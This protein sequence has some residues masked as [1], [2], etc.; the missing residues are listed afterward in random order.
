MEEQPLLSQINRKEFIE[1]C[2]ELYFDF[3]LCLSIK[4]NMTPVHEIGHKH[5]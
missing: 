2:R 5:T 4:P 1:L 3:D